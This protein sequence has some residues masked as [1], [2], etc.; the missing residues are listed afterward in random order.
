VRLFPPAIALCLAIPAPVVAQSAGALIAAEPVP[1]A[2]PGAQAWRIRYW[3]T[4]NDGSPIEVTGLVVAP[5]NAPTSTRRPVIAWAHGTWGVVEKCAPSLSSN[6]FAATPGLTEALRRGYAVVAP[7]YPGLGSAHTHGYLVGTDTAHSVLDAVRAARNIPG[8]ATGNRFAVWGESQG[9]H[10]ALWTG[11][12]W[13]AYAPDL[14]LIGIAAAA[15]PT[16]LAENLRAGSDPSI[17]AF[18]TAF[19]A[20]SWSQQFGAPLATLGNRATQSVITRLAQNNCIT[21]GK[22]P[23][24]GTMLGVLALR[25]DL[26]TVDLGSIQPWA[27]IARQ[28]SPAAT[29]F[30]VPVLIAQNP[31]DVIVAPAVTQTFARKL[32]GAGS[33]VRYLSIS[34]QGHETSAKDSSKATLDWIDARFDGKAARSDCGKI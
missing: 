15:P 10:A 3:T 2:P 4:G 29:D 27:R 11:H 34:G 1:E 23:R 9:G 25:R 33:R 18:L 21:L 31:K 8:A 30:G 12:R 24:L 14:R 26:K 28:N 32:C 6:V 5:R 19:T 13:Q 16:D 22:K 20:Y 17:R 7:D